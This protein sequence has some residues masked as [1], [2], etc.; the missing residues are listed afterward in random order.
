[1]LT[2]VMI[3][4]GALFVLYGVASGMEFLAKN[5]AIRPY[6]RRC[7][8]CRRYGCSI[9]PSGFQLGGSRNEFDDSWQWG[10]SNHDGVDDDRCDEADGD[11]GDCDEDGD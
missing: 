4:L 2:V 9:Q 11:G 10:T 7:G 6:S 5:G 1:M 3:G 8:C